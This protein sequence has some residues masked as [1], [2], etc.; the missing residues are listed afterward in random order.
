MKKL[1]KVLISVLLVSVM[2][3]SLYSFNTFA[4]NTIISFS[5]NSV[6]VGDTVTV[7]VSFNAGEAMYGLECVINYNSNLLEYKSGNAVGSAGTLN[8]VE[9]PSGETKTSYKLTFTAKQAGSCPVSIVD[10]SYS[11]QT[12]DKG[13][14]GAAATLTIHDKTLSNNANLKSLYINNGT[15]SPAFSPNVTTYEVMV[16]NSIT[17]CKVSATPADSGAKTTVEGSATLK[18]GKNTR[19]VVVTAPS[20][21]TKRYTINITRSETDDEIPV[22]ANPLEIDVDGT[23]MLIATDISTVKMFKGFTAKQI[24]YNEGKVSVAV[25]ENEEFIIYYLKEANSDVL[26][27]YTYDEKNNLFEKLK[28][29]SQG[30]NSYIFADIP[31]DKSVP[32]AFYTTN[33]QIDGMNV[34]CYA[35]SGS[36]M[37]DFYYI[38]CYFDGNYG[39]YRYDNR[40]NVIQRYPEMELTEIKTEVIKEK[41]DGFLD[42]FNSLSTN[43]KVI[44]IAIAFV[45]LAILALIVIVI[46]KLFTKKE[47]NEFENGVISEDDFED[48]ILESFNSSDNEN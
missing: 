34:K 45:G 37:S 42:R 24:D 35:S 11:G 38:Y 27:P 7:T 30:E 8:L 40:E 39:F 16:K 21:D 19:T 46:V 26:V 15:L 44:V 28:Y 10:C 3:F 43:A 13:I 31:S 47:Y 20:G 22:E 25:D 18:V 32:E 12:T 23:K 48:V 36:N 17:E 5:K 4:A 9:S 29:F 33:A 41:S 6:S 2:M 1:T 14:T